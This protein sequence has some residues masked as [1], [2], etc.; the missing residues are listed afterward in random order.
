MK[1]IL[2]NGS[3]NKNGCTYTALSIVA[4]E[5]EKNGIETEIIYANEKEVRHCTAC[6]HCIRTK[7][8]RC[9]FDDDLVNETSEKIT[10]ADGLILG[11]PVH[12]SS[13]ASI[14]SAFFCRLFYPSYRISGKFAHKP[15]AAVVCCR[16][17]GGTATYEQIMKYFAV[18][19][20]PIVSSMYWNIIHGNKPED[21]M[22]D[23]E[24]VQ[25]L[26]ILGRDMAWLLKSIE[27]GKKSG[28]PAPPIE[29]KVR[30]DFIR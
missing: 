29:A 9:V 10:A 15:G 25:T 23:D 28:I 11:A 16:R 3:P 20:M 4:E 21:I 7:E 1:V 14:A 8:G 26:R 30:T 6:R 19:E 22:R 2:I 12:F 17:G 18:A 24:G 13:M 27:A 5:I